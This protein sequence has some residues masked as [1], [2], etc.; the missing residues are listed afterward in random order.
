MFLLDQMF[1]LCKKVFVQ[2]AAIRIS[3][4]P[5]R[6]PTLEKRKNH[7]MFFLETSICKI[8]ERQAVGV[9]SFISFDHHTHVM[10]LKDN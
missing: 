5:E 1:L 7:I 9:R 6:S 2:C 10:L 3:N 8:R 4:Y